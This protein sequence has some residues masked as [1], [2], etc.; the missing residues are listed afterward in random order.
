MRSPAYDIS[1]FESLSVK[2][3][4]ASGHLGYIRADMH[5]L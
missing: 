4:C 1:T 2:D 5:R 3:S